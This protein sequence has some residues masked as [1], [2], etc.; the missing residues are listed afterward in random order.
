MTIRCLMRGSAAFCESRAILD[1]SGW[2]VRF[3]FGDVT[4]DDEAR[5]VQRAGQ[6]VHVSPRAFDLLVALIRER[7]RVIPKADLHARLW[8]DTFVTDASLAMLVAEVRAAIG[9]SARHSRWVRTVH[10]RGYAFQEADCGVVA[11]GRAE[12]PPAA[13]GGA[14]GLW[15]VSA[16]GRAP[17]AA[18]E[19]L[20]GRDPECPVLIDSP[21]VSRR[22]ARIVVDGDR[23]T[24]EDLG[25][26][27]GTRVG[28]QPIVTPTEIGVGDSVGFGAVSMTLRAR[29]SDPT[30]TED[31]P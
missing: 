9:D 27:N 28:G 19:N 14:T 4:V 10:R 12:A 26:K 1:S 13:S 24:V 6:S 3:V 20:V 17:L 7:P 29:P 31:G 23:V 18:G 25:S 2:R 22:H 30:L 8:P 11:A 21:S 16:A 5:H 15:L